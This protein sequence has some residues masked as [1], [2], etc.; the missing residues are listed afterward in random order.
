MNQVEALGG[1]C[2]ELFA[3]VKALEFELEKERRERLEEAAGGA[4]SDEIVNQ[5]KA[6]E[7]HPPG[8][9]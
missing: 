1:L 7:S 9:D 3:R 6:M 2:A 8:T 4:P 5:R